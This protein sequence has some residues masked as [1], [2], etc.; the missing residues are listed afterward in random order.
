MDIG[1]IQTNFGSV[2]SSNEGKETLL[3]KFSKTST[4]KVA[5]GG[6]H[7]T[8][9]Q[10][11]K[12]VSQAAANELPREEFSPVERLSVQ[13]I[14]TAQ[15]QNQQTQN[16]SIETNQHIITPDLSTLDFEGILPDI[17]TKKAEKQNAQNKELIEQAKA[18][19]KDGAAPKESVTAANAQLNAKA[20]RRF[21]VGE[22]QISEEEGIEETSELSAASESQAPT[23]S[24]SPPN[25]ASGATIASKQKLF[26]LN[27]RSSINFLKNMKSLNEKFSPE[28]V[29][30]EEDSGYVDAQSTLECLGWEEVVEYKPT[31]Y[32]NLNNTNLTKFSSTA[33]MLS[34]AQEEGIQIFRGK[35]P[36]LNKQENFIAIEKLTG[37]LAILSSLEQVNKLRLEDNILTS[38]NVAS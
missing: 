1:N 24:S 26:S 7:K 14:K 37:E 31:Y 27:L 9:T 5:V 20:I 33:S 36:I 10:Q 28:I 17:G 32:D 12:E 19:G 29:I 22:K 8:L 34:T 30:Y 35:H 6:V 4:I 11:F 16:S 38:N 21:S 18:E 15:L 25:L 3:D 23:S 2:A 13:E